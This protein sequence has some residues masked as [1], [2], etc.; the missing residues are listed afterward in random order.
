MDEAIVLYASVEDGKLVI[1]RQDGTPISITTHEELDGECIEVVE[2]GCSGHA[3]K[4]LQCLLNLHGQHLEEDGVFGNLTQT[5]LLIFQD[6]NRIPQTG[7]CSYL[8][9]SLLIGR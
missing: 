3:V 4:A 9:W 6:N 1:E 5:A 2:F 7:V 8:E